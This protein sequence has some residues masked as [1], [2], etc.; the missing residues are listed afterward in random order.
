MI[1]DKFKPRYQA[2]RSFQLDLTVFTK[3]QRGKKY[4]VVGSYDNFKHGSVD[5]IMQMFLDTRRDA[6]TN[7]V[8]YLQTYQRTFIIDNL[9][10]EL[11][12]IELEGALTD[13]QL[14]DLQNFL[15]IENRIFTASYQDYK[16][17]EN[18]TFFD[19]YECNCILQ[20]IEYREI[21]NT[22]KYT[23]NIVLKKTSN[24]TKLVQKN[25]GDAWR[26]NFL[27]KNFYDYTYNFKYGVDVADL[28]TIQFDSVVNNGNESAPYILEINEPSTNLEFWV[29]DNEGEIVGDFKVFGTY[30]AIKI[31]SQDIPSTDQ[32][33]T[34]QGIYYKNLMGEWVEIETYDINKTNFFNF[35]LG[36]NFITI[37]GINDINEETQN[38]SVSVIVLEQF[39]I[40]GA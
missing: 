32:E 7:T 40:V 26:W 12:T 1:Y 34:K 15:M 13:G 21:Q 38:I 11:G 24:W 22:N 4:S 30:Q 18:L 14:Y 9:E 28:T 29:I 3:F 19:V 35:V 27:G 2:A 39:R 16:A 17:Q 20:D 10:K 8:D 6:W 36:D 5:A 23:V 31:I 25:S 33:I 37:K